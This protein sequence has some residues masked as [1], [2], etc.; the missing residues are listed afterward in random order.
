MQSKYHL[1]SSL[2]FRQLA[3]LPLLVEVFFSF[4]ENDGS[5]KWMCNCCDVPQGRT[6]QETI[7]VSDPKSF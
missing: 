7:L 4:N 2:L 5:M 3:A 6:V 1:P